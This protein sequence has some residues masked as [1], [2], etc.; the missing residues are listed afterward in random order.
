MTSVL[1]RLTDREQIIIL[2]TASTAFVAGIWVGIWL[3]PSAALD[4]PMNTRY[5]GPEMIQT[6]AYQPV[7]TYL[8]VLSILVLVVAVFVANSI[9]VRETTPAFPATDGGEDER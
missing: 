6:P 4:V 7:P 5:H 1:S 3:I 9:R 8:P 2:L